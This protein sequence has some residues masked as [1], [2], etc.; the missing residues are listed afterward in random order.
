MQDGARRRVREAVAIVIS[1]L[2]GFGVWALS[3]RLVETPLPWDADWP[4]YPTVLLGAGFLVSLLAAKPWLGFFGVWTGQVVALVVLPLDRTTNM[5]GSTA[6]W[7]L[8][9]VS[10]GFGA[11]ILVFGWYLGKIFHRRLTRRA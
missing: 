8:G 1:S 11:L 6:W 3:P 4:F 5:L 7:V 10:T 9:V 2:V